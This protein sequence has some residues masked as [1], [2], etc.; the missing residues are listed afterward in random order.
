MEV[1]GKTGK[2][3][4]PVDVHPQKDI[5][6]AGT[7][8]T[9]EEREREVFKFNFPAKYPKFFSPVTWS[10]VEYQNVVLF[11][12][13]DIILATPTNSGRNGV[14]AVEDYNLLE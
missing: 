10:F 7:A 6:S 2:L 12:H 5:S 1:R 8:D 14:P 13:S 4:N 11:S 9:Q 3:Y